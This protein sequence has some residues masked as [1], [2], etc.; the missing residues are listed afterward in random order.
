M[1]K[2]FKILVKLIIFLGVMGMFILGAP[3]SILAYPLHILN[4]PLCIRLS[5]FFTYTLWTLISWMFNLSST[6]HGSIDIGNESY[7]VISNHIGSVDFI[8]INEIA[9][10]SG[11]ISHVK[12]AVKDG[13]R[14]FP[15]FY[16]IIVYVGFLVLKRSFEKDKKKIIRYLEFFNTSGIP[17]WFVFYP[18]GSRFSEELKLKSWKYSDEKGMARLNNVLFPRYKG[19]KLICENLKNSRIKKIVDV[20]FSYS[21][22]EVPPLWKFL[23]CDTTGIFNCDIRVVSIDEI[24]DYE[25]FLYK[26][27][28]RKDTL[29]TKWNSNATK[30]K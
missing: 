1:K 18:E 8:L 16:Q 17:I 12:Y 7:F 25:K 29:I 22:N 3:F 30:E 19:F 20:T 15:V 21:E 26:S 23:F 28:E 11:M 13:L 14:V 6:V 5:T 9:R 24:D 27:F 4:K 10:K 2:V